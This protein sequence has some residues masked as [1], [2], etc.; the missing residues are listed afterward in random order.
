MMPPTDASDTH[1]TQLVRYVLGRLGAQ[2]TE[3]LDEASI[4]DDVLASRLRIVENDLIDRYVRRSLDRE[5]L[6]RF[7]SYYLSS[8]R[9]RARVAFAAQ[10]VRLV[11]AVPDGDR[12][13]PR[14]TFPA[15]TWRR[16]AVA[17]LVI[18]ACGALLQMRWL[19]SAPRT[20]PTANAALD[21]RL[22]QA[23]Q[24]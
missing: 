20:A 11:D 24:P 2:Q 10:F 16:P 14:I 15:I 4:A 19:A 3:R 6:A 13:R 21:A 22:P 23:G 8:P 18:L 1:D 7:E 12:Q 5:T 9:R 17:A